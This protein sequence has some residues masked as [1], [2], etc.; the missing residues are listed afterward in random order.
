V[1]KILEDFRSGQKDTA[2][3]WLHLGD[4]YAYIQYFAL[5]DENGNYTGTIEVSQ[6]IKEIQQIQGEKEFTVKG[7][8]KNSWEAT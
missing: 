2:D 7:K 1:Q 3:F 5:R 4:K 6:D 8:R